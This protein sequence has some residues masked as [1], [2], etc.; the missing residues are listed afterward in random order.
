MQVV[1]VT[2]PTF[3]DGCWAGWGAGRIEPHCCGACCIGT[4][5]D[6]SQ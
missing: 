3:R 4:Q 2:Q 5:R 1:R 6:P